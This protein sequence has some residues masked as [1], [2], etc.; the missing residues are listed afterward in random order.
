[1]FAEERRQAILALL[2]DQNRV[3]VGSLAERFKV[4]EDTIRRDLRAL[5]STGFFQ[6]THGGAV[7]LNVASLDWQARAQLQPGLKERIGKAAAALVSPR[8][9]V[10]STR[11]RPFWRWP[12]SSRRVRSPRSRAHSTLPRLASDPAVSLV[13]TGGHW[14][15]VGRYL[16]G[17]DALKVIAA[18]RADWVFLGTCALHPEAGLTVQH[19]PD[20][21]MKRA[22]LAAGLRTVLLVDHTKFG[23]LAPNF[24]A[25]LHSVHAI[26]TDKKT[27]WLAKAGPRIIVA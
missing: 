1:M 5:A 8:E 10:M 9:T 2:A 6:K 20:A 26:V 21:T 19:A 23:G 24:V 22:M 17:D 4:S 14:D 11:A 25:P 27:P 7:A 3:E 13:V 15:P 12:N 16:S 18:D